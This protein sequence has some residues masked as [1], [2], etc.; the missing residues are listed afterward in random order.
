[1][2]FAELRPEIIAKFSDWRYDWF[3]EKHEGPWYWSDNIKDGNLEILEV[4]ARNV[5][6]PI[7]KTQL[8]NITIN[9]CIVSHNER[10][11]TI[12]LKNF[13]FY[14]HD[15]SASYLA[16]CYQVENENLYVATVYHERYPTP[17]NK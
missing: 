16:I 5:L 3:V 12:F 4:A 13:T 15:D 8:K 6:L 9:E 2:K 14:E 17:T 11:L 7:E 10:V 1:M